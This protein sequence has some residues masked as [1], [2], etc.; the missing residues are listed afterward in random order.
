MFNL[1]RVKVNANQYTLKEKKKKY[2]MWFYLHNINESK[3]LSKQV[4]ITTQA[5]TIRFG[6]Q[7]LA[8]QGSLRGL[9]K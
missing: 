9:L 7:Y 3:V 4:M 5:V 6:S 2:T 8:E 1:S